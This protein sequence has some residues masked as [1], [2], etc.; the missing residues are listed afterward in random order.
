M[1][2]F[3]KK[4]NF[5]IIIFGILFVFLFVIVN[6]SFNRFFD[7]DEFESVHTAWKIYQ[8][9]TIY[10][11]FFQHHHPLFYYLIV[12]F[13]SVLGESVSTILALRGFIFVILLGI[14]AVTYFL[15][16]AIFNNKRVSAISAVTISSFVVFVN[17]AIEIRPDVLQ[18]FFGLLSVLFLF[19]FLDK[20]RSKDLILS[21][22]FL[23]VSFLV[24]QKA[25]FLVILIF[26]TL[27]YLFARRVIGMR[28][29]LVYWFIFLLTLLPFAVYLFTSVGFKEYFMLNWELNFHFLNKFSP[30]KYFHQAVKENIITCFFYLV[31]SLYLVKFKKI[32]IAYFLSVGLLLSV[33]FVRSPYTQ[34]YMMSIPFISIISAFSINHIFKKSFL[35]LIVVLAL[36]VLPLGILSSKIDMSNKGQLSKINYVLLKTDKNDFVYDGDTRFNVFRKDLDFFWFSVN[37]EN[38]GL[39]TYKKLYGY[40]YDVNNLI[41]KVEPA[42][43]SDYELNTLDGYIDLNYKK[44][45][46]FNDLFIK[47]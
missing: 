33:M 17:N 44:S 18:V 38:R 14:I 45:E 7:H 11:D 24:L 8:G 31:G 43:I 37:S 19:Y 23:S 32:R 39:A 13:I 28:S 6:N 1:L 40:E 10:V 21:S 42:I 22:F 25:L 26:I 12:P 35:I 9:E 27:I 30:F 5:N 20:Q 2:K 15:S 46:K 29:L 3:V 16:N 36:S 41:K 34:Y 4:N 47:K